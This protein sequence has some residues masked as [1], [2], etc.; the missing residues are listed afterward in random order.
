MIKSYDEIGSE[1]F[2]DFDEGRG[3]PHL[4]PV[5]TVFRLLGIRPISIRL[6]RTR[7]GWHMVIRCDRCFTPVEKV[8]LQAVL[9]S[10]ARRESLNLMRVINGHGGDK[11]W[12]VL[13]REKLR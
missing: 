4:R 8:A 10:D 6:D 12:N 7:R 9:G 2:C 5:W 11:R 1:V 3:S 13:Y